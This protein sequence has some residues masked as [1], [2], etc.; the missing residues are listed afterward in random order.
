MSGIGIV[1]LLIITAALPVIA[2][3]IWFRITKSPVTLLWFLTSLTAGILSIFV[4]VLIQRLFPPPG[5]DGLWVMLFGVFI[6][7]AL[8][9]E[10]SRLAGLLI[11]LALIKQYR[12]IDTSFFAAVGFV[13][14]LGFAMMESAIYG[15]A[16]F[17]VILLRGVTAAPLHAAC[18]IRVCMALLAIRKHPIKALFLFI[19][20]VLIHGAYNLMIISPALPSLL[21]IPI[22]YAALFASIHHFTKPADNDDI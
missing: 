13:S 6:R 1:L 12:K 17:G 21:A 19:S 15:I 10:I 18:A 5:I 7:V 22:A 11:L 14:G 9:E 2:V 20:A 16:D 3:F 8:V 4:A